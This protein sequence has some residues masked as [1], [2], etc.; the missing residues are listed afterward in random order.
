MQL[1]KHNFRRFF[2]RHFFFDEI[3]RPISST[4][5]YFRRKHFVDRI[6]G[7]RCTR[8]RLWG[9]M[10]AEPGCREMKEIPGGKCGGQIRGGKTGVPT[11][12]SDPKEP[13]TRGGQI[14]EGKTGG[15]IRGAKPGWP[16]PGAQQRIRT[17]RNHSLTGAKSGRSNPGARSGAP[18]P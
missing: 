2:R 10:T 3:C 7:H 9:V 11:T 15:Q 12:D 17:L 18:N 6:N 8:R 4:L 13:L 1:N 14:R 5:L 16:K